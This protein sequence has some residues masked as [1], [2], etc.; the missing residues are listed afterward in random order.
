M[1]AVMV[2]KMMTRDAGEGIDAFIEKRR[3]EWTGS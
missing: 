1:G 3:P 2:R